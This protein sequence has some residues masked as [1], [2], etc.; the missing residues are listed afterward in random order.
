MAEFKSALQTGVQVFERW[1]RDTLAEGSGD[2]VAAAQA[3]PVVLH[4]YWRR[5]AT[6]GEAI[7]G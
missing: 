3:L 2:L 7:G 4:A 5:L 1:Q 6:L